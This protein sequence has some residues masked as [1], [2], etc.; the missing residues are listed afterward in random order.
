MPESLFPTH[1]ILL[2]DDDEDLQ[3]SYAYALRND[4]LNHLVQCTDSRLVEQRLA[5]EEFEIVLLDLNMPY[6][7]GRDLLPR[8]VQ[9]YP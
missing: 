5:E 6:I 4:G 3:R 7:S 2:V 9:Q 8:I 1:P